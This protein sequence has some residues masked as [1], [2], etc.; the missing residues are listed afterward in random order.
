MDIE[1]DELEEIFVLA[2]INSD[3]L[4]SEKDHGHEM[5]TDGIKNE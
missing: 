1:K 4:L 2:S 5:Q 3:Q